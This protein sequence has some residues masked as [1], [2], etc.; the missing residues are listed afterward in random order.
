[1]GSFKH[2]FTVDY[3]RFYNSG[4]SGFASQFPS[5]FWRLAFPKDSN[6]GLEVAP[7]VPLIWETILKAVVPV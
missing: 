3:V 4:P 6:I 2:T 1:M 7:S 5:V